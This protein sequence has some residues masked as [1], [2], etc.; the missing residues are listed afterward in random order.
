MAGEVTC[1]PVFDNVVMEMCGTVCENCEHCERL[2]LELHK[3]LLELSS[4]LT[5]IKL[6]H[7]NGNQTH[8]IYEWT[9]GQ[10]ADQ[11]VISAQDIGREGTWMLV[12]SDRNK[13]LRKPVTRY[14]QSLPR[15][16]NQY[17]VLQN[18]DEPKKLCTPQVW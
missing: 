15:S 9:S 5:V 3:T 10:K 11:D 16:V 18:L 6:L 2:R 13:R 7:E 1:S 12:N 4:A 14:S 8:P 17:E